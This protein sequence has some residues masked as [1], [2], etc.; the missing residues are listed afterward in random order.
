MPTCDPPPP[1]RASLARSPERRG[2][3]VVL[4]MAPADLER[5]DRLR[6]SASR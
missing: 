2:Q 4:A 1:A 3:E 6:W 5:I